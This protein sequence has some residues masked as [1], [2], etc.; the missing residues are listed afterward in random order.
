MDQAV[1][2]AVA[3]ACARNVPE[4]V[5]THDNQALAVVRSRRHGNALERQLEAG[6]GLAILGEPVEP[7]RVLAGPDWFGG[8]SRQLPS[9]AALP[10]ATILSLM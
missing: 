5:A 4:I 2:E 3:V 10:S 1:A 7:K 8:T 9:A 6:H